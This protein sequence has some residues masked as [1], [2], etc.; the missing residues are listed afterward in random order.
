LGISNK[1]VEAHVSRALLAL[2][3][4]LKSCGMLLILLSGSIFHFT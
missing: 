2:R 1:A 4:G 3:K